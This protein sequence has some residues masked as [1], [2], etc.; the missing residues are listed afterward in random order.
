MIQCK[1][2]AI[3]YCELVTHTEDTTSMP[4][5]NCSNKIQGLVNCIVDKLALDSDMLIQ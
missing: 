5:Y 1:L 2:L 3:L 4:N